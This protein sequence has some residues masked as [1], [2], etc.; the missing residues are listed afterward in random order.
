[1]TATSYAHASDRMDI[2]KAACRALAVHAAVFAVASSAGAVMLGIVK[3]L[4]PGR[5]FALFLPYGTGFG[6]QYVKHL[7]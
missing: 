6:R 1:M 5:L 7:A 2:H 3:G 4:I